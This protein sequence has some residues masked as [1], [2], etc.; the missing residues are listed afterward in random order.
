MK[1]M[2]LI[3][4]AGRG[5]FPSSLENPVSEEE[6]PVMEQFRLQKESGMS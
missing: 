2:F 6:L 4:C 1:P 5:V 3:G